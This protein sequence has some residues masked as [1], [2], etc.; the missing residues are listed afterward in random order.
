M[1]RK[2]KWIGHTL[3]KSP[4]EIVHSALQWNPQG[5][6]NRGRPRM[7]WRRSISKETTKSFNELK[8]ITRNR[9]LWKSYVDRL[10]S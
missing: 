9:D 2:Y 3:R 7:T 8:H 4:D 5:S 1:R 10:S 6:R